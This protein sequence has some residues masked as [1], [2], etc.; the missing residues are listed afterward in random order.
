ML[1]AEVLKA[2]QSETSFIL[3]I[4]T[5][6]SSESIYLPQIKVHKISDD[7]PLPELTEAFTGQDAIISTLPGQLSTIHIRLIDAAVEAGVKRFIPSE[8]GNNTCAAASDFVPLYGIKAKVIECLRTREST[9]LTWTAIHTGQFFDWGLETGWLHYDLKKQKSIILDSG[10]KAWSTSTL[11]T[12][13]AAIVKVLL[14]PEE[15]KNRPVFVASFTLSQRQLL[16][17]LEKVGGRKWEVE[18]ISSGEALKKVEGFDGMGEEKEALKLR[19][20]L[21]LGSEEVD[22]GADFEKDGVLDN[23]MLGLPAENLTKVVERV[24][25]HRGS[26]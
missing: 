11:G 16:G 20:L 14:K 12:A 7:Y 17:A 2:L 26:A 6:K 18:T 21:V 1:G 10:N 25:D 13:S 24:L 5:R 22:R 23:E 8:F 4:L 19:M 9:G 3:S 15:T